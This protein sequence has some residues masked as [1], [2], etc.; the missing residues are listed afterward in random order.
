[1][2]LT[3]S[4]NA[5]NIPTLRQL[6]HD[7]SICLHTLTKELPAPMVRLVYKPLQE[8]V[9]QTKCKELKALNRQ[10]TRILGRDFMFG[11]SKYKT[12]KKQFEVYDTGV[13]KLKA[14]NHP[15]VLITDA[16]ISI[17][18]H[19]QFKSLSNDSP[20][21]NCCGELMNI[22]AGRFG[23]FFVCGNKCFSQKSVSAQHWDKVRR[24]SFHQ[25][26]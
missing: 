10:L 11:A 17:L 18:T 1:M 19:S 2:D 4:S 3:S 8:L 9:E 14:L 15:Y 20:T 25:Q 13:E 24:T 26:A 21:C 5:K 23:E 6:K 7:T 16:K 12:Q 22:K